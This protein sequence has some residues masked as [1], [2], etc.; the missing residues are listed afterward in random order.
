MQTHSLTAQWRL[1]MKVTPQI[2]APMID[3]WKMI[4]EDFSL[5]DAESAKRNFDKHGIDGTEE[6]ET[7]SQIV[8]MNNYYVVN[9]YEIENHEQNDCTYIAHPIKPGSNYYVVI[10]YDD[11]G[12]YRGSIR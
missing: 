8:K 7:Y 5:K 9:V 10:A 4:A 12:R 6:F 11:T 3:D 1:G 2:N